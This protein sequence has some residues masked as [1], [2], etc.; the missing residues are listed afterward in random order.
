MSRFFVTTAPAKTKEEAGLESSLAENSQAD[1]KKAPA[2]KRLA[3]LEQSVIVLLSVFLLVGYTLVCRYYPWRDLANQDI[4]EWI[5][6]FAG[7]CA[8]YC[9]E[10]KK[11]QVI[12]L[13]TSLITAVNHR[14]SQTK[15]SLS[16]SALEHQAAPGT[17]LVLQS[18]L[19]KALGDDSAKQTLSMTAVPGSMM[20]DQLLILQNLITHGKKPELLVLTVAPRDYID[21]E[22]KS[23]RNSPVARVFFFLSRN[24][25]YLPHTLS[26]QDIEACLEG[27]K[28]FIDLLRTDILRKVKKETCRITGHPD[29][30]WTATNTDFRKD[31]K[32]QEA[33]R[34]DKKKEQVDYSTLPE[35]GRKN[36]AR[37]LKEDLELYQKRYMPFNQERMQKQLT[38]Y[39]Q[40]LQT[41]RKE[42]ISVLVLFMP[43]SKPNSALLPQGVLS[44]LKVRVFAQAKQ[45]GAAGYDLEN[46][47]EKSSGQRLVL[48]DFVDSVHVN[49]AGAEKLIGP[50]SKLIAQEVRALPQSR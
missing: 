37:A 8:D 10:G 22:N 43:V 39:E 45:N 30:L 50:I 38:A 36:I 31:L 17:A 2:P 27:H 49:K 42:N 35:F 13:G 5:I 23:A 41:A 11:S 46:E 40:L 4:P 48:D 12:V 14:L 15:Q 28:T 1:C 34:K 47:V 9:L 33:A 25:N 6:S 32:E 21:N 29:S 7:D 19:N 16:Q 3:R 20:T 44:D 26:P 24:Q 18:A